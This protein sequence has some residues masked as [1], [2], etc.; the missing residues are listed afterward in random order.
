[1]KYLFILLFALT[2]NLSL[3]SY[4]GGSGGGGESNPSNDDDGGYGSSS[5]A[6]AAII[7][8][9]VIGY[10]ILRDDEEADEFANKDKQ[11]NFEINFLNEEQ[12]LGFAENSGYRNDFQ[13]N[14]KYYLN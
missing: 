5:S 12:S 6:A 10:F 2:S 3:A 1:M 14:F 13:V 7:G 4:H 11:R 9:G 8:V